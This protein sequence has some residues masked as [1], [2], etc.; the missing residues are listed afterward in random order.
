MLTPEQV[1]EGVAVELKG[2][3]IGGRHGFSWDVR[4]WTVDCHFKVFEVVVQSM[5]FV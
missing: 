2:T 5:N 3:R 4:S 1:L